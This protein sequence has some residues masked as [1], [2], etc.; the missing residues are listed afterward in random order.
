MR[1]LRTVFV[2]GLMG[3]MACGGSSDGGDGMPPASSDDGGTVESGAD[4]GGGSSSGGS[5]SSGGPQPSD[6]GDKDAQPDGSACAADTK[7]DPMNCGACG[8]DCLGAKCSGGLCAP[9]GVGDVGNLTNIG[10]DF[11]LDANNVYVAGQI[12]EG[13]KVSDVIAALPRSGGPLVV[14]A[15]TT[16]GAWRGANMLVADGRVFW[17]NDYHAGVLSVPITA[18][19]AAATVVF[20]DPTDL[21]PLVGIAATKTTLYFIQA[22]SGLYS[23]SLP[24]GAY[25][26][27]AQFSC[28][29]I[30][31]D[32]LAMDPAG[33]YIYVSDNFDGQVNQIATAD[34]SQATVANVNYPYAVAADAKHVY[35]TDAGSCSGNGTNTTCTGGK[36]VRAAPSGQSMATLASGIKSSGTWGGFSSLTVDASNVY[37]TVSDQGPGALYEHP[38]SGGHTLKLATYASFAIVDGSYVYYSGGGGGVARVSK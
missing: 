23:A 35:W 10:D 38:I 3:S 19:N 21:D 30:D 26:T 22:C 12:V 36:V 34:G 13:Q 7:T 8:H 2:L 24:T 18:Q 15:K 11:A 14:L 27:V 17:S 16:T 9:E 33:K 32:A 1:T 29:G 4:S 37:Y 25:Q 28:N 20:D 5:S 6:A 31:M